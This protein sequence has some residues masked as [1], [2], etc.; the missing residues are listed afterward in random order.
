MMTAVVM[1]IRNE[2][3]LQIYL[4]LFYH[5]A[6]KLARREKNTKNPSGILHSEN[7]ILTFAVAYG[8][9]VLRPQKEVKY[10]R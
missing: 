10:G 1:Y 8:K 4:L 3:H 6:R 5:E 9:I 7:S 2:P